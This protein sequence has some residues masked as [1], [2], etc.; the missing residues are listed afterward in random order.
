M[1]EGFARIRMYGEK[2]SLCHDSIRQVRWPISLHTSDGE[3]IRPLLIV[4]CGPS[5]EYVNR[6]VALPLLLYGKVRCYK[7]IVCPI[8]QPGR[9]AVVLGNRQPFPVVARDKGEVRQRGFLEQLQQTLLRVNG[10]HLSARFT[11]TYCGYELVLRFMNTAEDRIL[12]PC[13]VDGAMQLV[14]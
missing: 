13:R 8:H 6:T 9:K 10:L 7:R 14:E 2:T 4:Q 3:G 1:I 12:P 5:P 11:A